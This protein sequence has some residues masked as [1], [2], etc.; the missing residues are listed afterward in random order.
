MGLV[1][2]PGMMTG[3]IIAG[4]SPLV[5][6][7]YQIIIVFTI[8]SAVTLSSVLLSMVIYRLYF[9]KEHQLIMPLSTPLR[10]SLYSH[11]VIRKRTAFHAHLSMLI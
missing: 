6:V 4:E 3:A 10:G 11:I 2:L 5:A 7:R 1:Q 8:T 9:T